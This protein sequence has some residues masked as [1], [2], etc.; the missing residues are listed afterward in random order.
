MIS[1]SIVLFVRT[2]KKGVVFGDA[3]VSDLAMPKHRVR[4][5]SLEG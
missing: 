5:A 4:S 3:L 1:L 2:K